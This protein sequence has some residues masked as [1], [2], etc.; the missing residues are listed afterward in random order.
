VIWALLYI[1][2]LAALVLRART[3][4]AAAPEPAFPLPGEPVWLVRLHH[5]LFLA[6]FLAAP[7]EAVLVGG[8]A[9]W[10]STGALLFLAGVGAY[11]VAGAALG[12]ALSPL[13]E[14]RPGA[15]LVTQGPYRWLRHPMYLGQAL[16]A[17]GAP[18]VLGCRWTLTISA[19]AIVAL[20]ARVL[21]EEAA[22][23][24]TFPEY[25]RYAAQTKRILPF[26]F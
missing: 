12:E 24:R 26:V 3:I 23:A 14:P 2:L 17:V 16:I 1:G 22:L 5:R 19:A 18:L 8:R 25:A 10:R 6:L 21:L 9:A 7:L 20:G 15:A 11:R 13:I 4:P